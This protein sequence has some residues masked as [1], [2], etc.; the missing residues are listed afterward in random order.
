MSRNVLANIT[1][2]IMQGPVSGFFYHQIVGDFIII[3]ISSIKS[4]P[5][6]GLL[7]IKTYITNFDMKSTSNV[8]RL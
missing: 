5:L 8:A 3:L 2:D 7:T 4:D 1:T 6:T